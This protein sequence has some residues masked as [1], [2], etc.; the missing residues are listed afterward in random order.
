M[1]ENEKYLKSL[2]DAERK[3][4]LKAI[5][6]ENLIKSGF[7]FGDIDKI[8]FEADN[9]LIRAGISKGSFFLIDGGPS[10]Y[11]TLIN[12]R[13]LLAS[14]IAEKI[15]D[16][17]GLSNIAS[18]FFT[19]LKNRL[20]EWNLSED[21]EDYKNVQLLAIWEVD[22]LYNTKNERAISGM[23]DILQHR[24]TNNKPTIITFSYKLCKERMVSCGNYICALS[25][26]YTQP[27]SDKI[28]KI[29]V[30]E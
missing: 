6:K 14:T 30:K 22:D 1:E 13:I 9:E 10:V 16:M 12:N 7:I 21:V 4:E 8:Q 25:Q 18:T 3:E 20:S 26:T 11:L 5:R 27:N 29:T 23:D 17:S 2:Y 28:V 19:S 24:I 15:V